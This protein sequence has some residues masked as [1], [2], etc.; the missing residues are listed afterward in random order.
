MAGFYVLGSF[1]PV[2]AD[3][4][5]IHSFHTLLKPHHMPGALDTKY[6]FS[7][8]I[9]KEQ[10]PDSEPGFSSYVF[11]HSSNIYCVPF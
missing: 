8:V 2:F 7:K 5:F 3:T 4:T 6:L 9:E 1:S 11:I 10:K